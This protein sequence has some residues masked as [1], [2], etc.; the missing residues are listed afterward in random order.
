MQTI[1]QI[2]GLVL[3]AGFF[4]LVLKWWTEGALE[5]V[6]AF[7][8]AV[9]YCTLIFVVFAAEIMWH[10]LLAISIIVASAAYVIN[11]NRSGFKKSFYSARVADCTETLARD[12]SNM[13]AREY[14]IDSLIELGRKEE[15]LVELRTAVELGAPYSIKH[16]L[17]RIEKDMRLEKTS[18]PVCLQCYEEFP[19]AEGSCPRCGR[20]L[21]RQ[22]SLAK[23]LSGGRTPTA[24]FYL[25]GII[26]AM[27]LVIS[28]VFMPPS[29]MLA[30]IVLFAIFLLGWYLIGSSGR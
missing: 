20:P 28:L 14:L 21:V 25:L 27:L 23:W 15:A 26:G 2:A 3:A 13:A 29:L 10:R 19:G 16:K 11:Y 17:E 1:M 24:R 9:V 22:H 4:F 30:P 5:T 7:T 18:N 8:V 12:P 6:D